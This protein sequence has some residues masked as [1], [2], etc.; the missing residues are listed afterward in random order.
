MSTALILL[1]SI[2]PADDGKMPLAAEMRELTL[3]EL[4][5][6]SWFGDWSRE[7]QRDGEVFLENGML[8]IAG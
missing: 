6:G 3:T 2:L 1:A 7:G 4:V 8:S 5:R